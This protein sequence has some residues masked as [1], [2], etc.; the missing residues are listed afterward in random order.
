MSNPALS[1]SESDASECADNSFCIFLHL[2]EGIGLHRRDGI[3]DFAERH[4]DKVILTATLNGVKFEVEG[5]S[6][7]TVTIFNSNCVWECELSDIKRMKTDNRPVKV[8]IFIKSG[9]TETSPRRGIG[10]LLLPIRGVPVVAALKN[11]QLKLHWHKLN[12]M[13]SEW[14]Q[15]KPEIYLLL[16]I[17]KKNLLEN[18]QFDVLMG[19]KC[20]LN[21]GLS[22]KSSETSL[23][24]QSQSNVYVQLLEQV[25][26]IQVG[27]NPDVDCDIFNVSLT[28][29]QVKNLMM[30]LEM[31][32]SYNRKTN[33]FVFHYDFLGSASQLEMVVNQSDC[34]T[35]NEKISLSFKSSLKS[36]RTYFQRIFYIPISVYINGA[37]V[38]NYRLDFSRLLPDDSFF[39]A[40]NV[41]SKNGTF[42]FDRINKI[43]SPRATKPSVDFI[44]C[45][46]LVTSYSKKSSY[47]L[48]PMSEAYASYKIDD[49]GS[50]DITER[51]RNLDFPTTMQQMRAPYDV[52]QIS[53]RNFSNYEI[54]ERNYMKMQADAVIIGH[55][56]EQ[57][58]EL[59]GRP[60]EDLSKCSITGKDDSKDSLTSRQSK[61]NVVTCYDK[62]VFH[63]K[64]S[65]LNDELSSKETRSVGVNTDPLDIDPEE[66]TIKIVQ[67][68]EDWK[69]Q[70][71]EHF[72][73]GL[74]Q[75]EIGYLA[76][77]DKQWEQQRSI[78]QARLEAKLSECEK[79]NAKLELAHAELNANALKHQETISI[80]QTVKQDIERSYAEKFQ[81]LDDEMQ[82]LK[83]E[84]QQRA[85]ESAERDV[86][87]TQQQT[88]AAEAN[89]LELDEKLQ[90]KMRIEQLE[91]QLA[92]MEKT[93]FSAEQLACMLADLHKQTERFADIEKAKNFYKVQWSKSTKEL[94]KLKLH[95]LKQQGKAMEEKKDENIDICLEE[96]LEE[97]QE[98][99]NS[100]RNELKYIKNLLYDSSESASDDELNAD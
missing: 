97:E 42:Y 66:M 20:V 81:Q 56:L 30:V 9:R 15:N 83:H 4:K 92:D 74:E 37:V 72:I 90:M 16:V 45:V 50:V 44:F 32:Q 76:E 60:S 98:A 57:N 70:Q 65:V 61:A 6:T 7:E 94:H 10:S 69:A 27:N 17:V 34:Y 5:H 1:A 39:N 85:T 14:R 28:F 62:Q 75:K 68:L 84:I 22:P 71:M 67:E 29:K 78:L 64:G 93:H 23:M 40:T 82:R 3:G 46:Q 80:V 77:L 54:Y 26:L 36:L 48:V 79:L 91:K 53:N 59:F 25:G 63:S 52:G 12:V 13:S 99:L 96:I 88:Q 24:L 38:A 51:Y 19:K 18:G 100:D 2:V 87:Q 49:K 11:L 41:F 58:G 43:I 21:D 73:R 33:V 86:E 55:V 95:L 89:D 31:E 35:I 47:E 8:E